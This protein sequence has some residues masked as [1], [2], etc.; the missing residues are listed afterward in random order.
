MASDEPAVSAEDVQ[1][2]NR[3]T[4]SRSA[5]FAQLAGTALIVVGALA[6]LGWLWLIVRQQQRAGDVFGFTFD[7]EPE[8]PTIAGRI[9]MITG[10]VTVLVQAALAV[11]IGCGLRLWGQDLASRVGTSLTG[12][13]VGDRRD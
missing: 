9:D 8:H 5:W 11:G 7:S 4:L 1:A 10:T 6:V 2:L 12:Y 3:A 13:E